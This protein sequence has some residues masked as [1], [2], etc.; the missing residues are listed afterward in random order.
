MVAGLSYLGDVRHWFWRVWWEA[1]LQLQRELSYFIDP[2]NTFVAQMA[3]KP[4]PPDWRKQLHDYL[5]A[6]EP[7]GYEVAAEHRP[8]LEDFILMLGG[9]TA[10]EHA[11]SADQQRAF[12]REQQLDH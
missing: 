2:L 11:V 7:D 6:W 9:G 5:D 12:A 1:S 4:L 3:S 8:I 10:P